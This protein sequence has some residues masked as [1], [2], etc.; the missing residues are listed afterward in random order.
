MKKIIFYVSLLSSLS[1]I[2]HKDCYDF[3]R[4]DKLGQNPLEQINT[5]LCDC[6][7]HRSKI[8]KLPYNKPCPR[9]GHK[10]LLKNK[11]S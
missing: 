3:F 11:Q 2:T 10:L 9:C 4:R 8:S 1:A 6:L 5:C 7:S